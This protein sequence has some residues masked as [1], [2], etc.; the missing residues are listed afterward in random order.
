MRRLIGLAFVALAACG[1]DEPQRGVDTTLPEDPATISGSLT[2]PNDTIPDDLQVCAETLDGRTAWCKAEITRNGYSGSYT[3]KVPGGSYRV[4]ARTSEAPG[5]KAYYKQC[6]S[7]DPECTSHAPVVIK[8][9]EGETREGVDIDDWAGNSA[10]PAALSDENV[11][12]YSEPTSSDVDENSE[13][14]NAD[15]PP[16]QSDQPA[17]TEPV[18]RRGDVRSVFS[19]DDYPAS[20]QAAGEQG[21]VQARLSVDQRGRVSDCAIVRSSG[22]TSLDSATCSI[23]SRRAQFSPARATDGSAVASTYVTPPIVWKLED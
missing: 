16:V 9:E 15:A 7:Q 12:D 4:F 1:S 20:A 5:Y 22:S 11:S 21:M 2:G 6:A 13:V 17:S 18:S 8:I 14:E 23:L 19:S 3:L 10:P